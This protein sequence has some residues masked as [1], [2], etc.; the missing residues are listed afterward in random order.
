MQYTNANT[1]P[2]EFVRDI[3]A[4]LSGSNVAD[5]DEADFAEL[6]AQC[7]VSATFGI[8]HSLNDIEDAV[9]SAFPYPAGTQRDALV[10]V[11]CNGLDMTRYQALSDAL[12]R[13]VPGSLFISV[14]P[15]S[16][17]LPPGTASIILLAIS[18]GNKTKKPLSHPYLKLVVEGESKGQP[19]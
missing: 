15:K 4:S 1:L 14:N 12:R 16:N 6:P 17:T 19:N 7:P 2:I 13:K 8:S 3:F 11:H 5:F 9:S 18:P 10:A